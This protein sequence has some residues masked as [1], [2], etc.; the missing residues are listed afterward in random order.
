MRSQISLPVTKKSSKELYMKVVIAGGSGQ[1]GT[2]VARVMIADGHDVVIL[3]RSPL[4]VACRAVEWDAESLG[5][6]TKPK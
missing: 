3:S 1:V 5:S 2:I 4:N 6:W